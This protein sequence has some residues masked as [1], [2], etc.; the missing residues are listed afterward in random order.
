MFFYWGYV[1]LCEVKL[2]VMQVVV[3]LLG[4]WQREVIEVYLIVVYVEKE[5]K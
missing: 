1:G 2:V 4:I 3:K 5:G